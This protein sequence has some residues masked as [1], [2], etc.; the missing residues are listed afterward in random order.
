MC[1]EFYLHRI[2]CNALI[3]I[4][5]ITSGGPQLFFCVWNYNILWLTVEISIHCE[6]FRLAVKTNVLYSC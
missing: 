2:A 4:N 6:K 3:Q 5:E 1:K